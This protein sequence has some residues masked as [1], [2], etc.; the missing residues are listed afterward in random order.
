VTTHTAPLRL[1][2]PEDGERLDRYL[3]AHTGI[4]RS[5]LQRLIDEGAVTVNGRVAKA[6]QKLDAGDAIEA[7]LRAPAAPSLA[8]QAMPLT[9]VYQD[10]DLVVIDKPAGLT[11]HPGAGHPDHTLVNAVLALAPALRE[12]GDPL[13]PGIV[14]RLDKD[15]SGLIVVAKHA[16]AQEALA[17]QFR[18]RTT[19][20]HY[21]A[22]IE[23]RLSPERGAI[24]APIGRDA[25]YR[26]RM[27]VVEGGRDARTTYQVREYLPHHTLVEVGL[28]TGRTHQIRVHFAAIGHP[29]TGDVVY[30]KPSPWCPRQFLHAWRLKFRRPSD[31]AVVEAEAPL[32]ADLEAALV[33]ARMLDA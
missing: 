28:E 1:T 22:L 20:K 26:Q 17:R 5:Q 10:A 18:D 23:G 9:V 11:V 14:H 31:G 30:G 16:A 4:T 21:L 6:G 12:S 8:A 15:T 3:A 7:D 25:R 13:R 24:E 27:T 29:V 33:A 32:P 19:E 2:V